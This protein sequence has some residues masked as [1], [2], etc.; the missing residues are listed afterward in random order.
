MVSFLAGKNP[1]QYLE[2]KPATS[3][4]LKFLGILSKNN[5]TKSE[6]EKRQ[7]EGAKKC[8]K[9]IGPKVFPF[10]RRKN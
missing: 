1:G 4:P 6:N 9:M 7:A 3:C 5:I 10:N 8:T 2:Q